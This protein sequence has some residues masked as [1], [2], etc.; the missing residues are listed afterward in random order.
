MNLNVG[1]IL[2]VLLLVPVIVFISC[3]NK[4]SQSYGPSKELPT[5]RLIDFKSMDIGAIRHSESVGVVISGKTL[6]V[7]FDSSDLN[8][9]IV[10]VAPEGSWDLTGYLYVTFDVKNMSDE[11]V[12]VTCRLNGEMIAAGGHVIPAGG[13][14]TVKTFIPH[15]KGIPEYI[16]DA[17]HGMRG[18]PGK[19]I[20]KPVDTY[21][22]QDIHTLMIKFPNPS[23]EHTLEIT[24]FR[25][26]PGVKIFTKEELAEGFF[27]FV[28]EFGQYMHEEWEEKIHS[29]KELMKSVD[30]EEDD[31]RSY[32][33][34]KD[35]DSYGGWAAGPQLE[36]T[37]SFRTEKYKGKW[38]LVDPEGRLF[39]SHGI[40]GVNSRDNTPITDREHYF[41]S[42]PPREDYPDL[43][44]DR[45][46]RAGGTT[47]G[48]YKGQ[49]T[50][51]F[52]ISIYNLM[53]KYGESWE[54]KSTD[55]SHRRLR[56]W[57]MNTMGGWS[58]ARMGQEQ[59]ISYTLNF[60]SRGRSIEG[61]EG[62]WRKFPDPFDEEWKKNLTERLALE[63]EGSA[64]DP[65]CIGYFIDNELGWGNNTYL[66]ES[67]LRS[68]ADQPV[69]LAFRE[70]LRG[71]YISIAGLNEAW[72]TNFRSW[73][74]FLAAINI[75]D[76]IE[77]DLLEFN[78]L[79]ARQY[80][81]TCRNE[82][83][84]AA[85]NK[86][87]MGARFDFHMYPHEDTTHN[88]LLKIAGDYCDIISFNRYRY[89]SIGLV[90]PEGVDKP[91]MI[92]EWHI[93]TLDRGMFHFGIRFA[94]SLEQ[95]KM[96]YR[97]YVQQALQNP[98]M[99]GT[100]WFK[101][102]D[103]TLTG[104]TDGENLRIG[105]VDICDQPYK[106]LVDASREIGY[107]LYNLRME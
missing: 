12:L 57:G 59:P 100:H 91:V 49:M 52:N 56:S 64:A 107:N 36:A 29:V 73:D 5:V 4:N 43:Y 19:L 2:K 31:L 20:V 61:S 16:I 67:A 39:W 62:F 48:R 53:R 10:L 17:F 51:L 24:G 81:G 7:S 9:G 78:A 72:K 70:H 96:F 37:G 69:K 35:W 82:I 22:V 15:N 104:R 76:N 92:T 26:E 66:A 14:G 40:G 3:L 85:P 99:V 101:Y 63:S 71:K 83:K 94:R 88:W 65:Y 13:K 98:Y 47:P 38:W 68:P 8:P 32:P 46:A 44:S 21:D 45:R 102:S 80:L 89:S 97:Y 50:T 28:D 55:Q 86:L 74:E 54:D 60:G 79:I 90:P 11:Q 6:K 1:D 87:Y 84:K 34:P 41:A 42:L 58:A 105:F 93:G 75:P 27:P 23:S 106:E 77:N 33:G 95:Q 18:W 25:A 103:Q 30:I